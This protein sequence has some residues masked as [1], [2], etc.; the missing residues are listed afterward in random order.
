[1]NYACY[2]G[3]YIAKIWNMLKIRRKGVKV[4]WWTMSLTWYTKNV[5]CIENREKK[6]LLWW[7]LYYTA[8][9][10]LASRD[11]IVDNKRALYFR[12]RFPQQ[13][14]YFH[15]F[16]KAFSTA[17]SNPTNEWKLCVFKFTNLKKEE[18]NIALIWVGY[19][20]HCILSLCKYISRVV[21]AEADMGGTLTNPP[22]SP[23]CV[24]QSQLLP[25]HQ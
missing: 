15:S 4:L 22:T 25:S 7:T 11:A 2:G 13:P 10:V 14:L 5:K 24:H 16:W 19:F 18:E 17:L 1:M 6:G 23:S 20:Y 3:R 8:I 9:T 12:S 21:R